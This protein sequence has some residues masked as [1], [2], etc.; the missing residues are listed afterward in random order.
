[1]TNDSN[2]P[3]G[4]ND[5]ALLDEVLNADLSAGNDDLQQAEAPQELSLIHI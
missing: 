5:A 4:V 2:M 3:E 1:M